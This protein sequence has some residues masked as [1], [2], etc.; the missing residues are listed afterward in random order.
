MFRPRPLCRGSF[1]LLVLKILEE[2]GEATGYDLMKELRRLTHE[3]YSPSPGHVYPLLRSLE[4]R[5]L[6][7]SRR[8]DERVLY[9]LTE[10]GKRELEER[11]AEAEELLEKIKLVTSDDKL[12]VHLALKK[13]VATI[14]VYSHA[15]VGEKAVEV[16]RIIEEARAKI[17]ELLSKR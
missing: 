11:R 14:F 5:G 7:A 6:V 17:E 8:I 2:R 1:G 12:S 13:L 3:L 16:S 15:V 4:R 10:R 9:S